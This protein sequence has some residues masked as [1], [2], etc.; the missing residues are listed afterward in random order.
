MRRFLFL[1]LLALVLAGLGACSKSSK[2]ESDTFVYPLTVGNEW[3]YRRVLHCTG[4]GCELGPD[5]IRCSILVRVVSIDTTTAP[6]PAYRL[7]AKTFFEDG[8][9]YGAQTLYQNRADGLYELA[10]EDT[11][12]A[13]F[14]GRPKAGEWISPIHAY[15]PPPFRT[16]DALPGGIRFDSTAWHHSSLLPLQYPLKGTWR[17]ITGNEEYKWDIDKTVRG[18]EKVTTKAG[19][20]DCFKI[21]W[22]YPLGIDVACTEYVSGYGLFK[23]IWAM[24]IMIGD[25]LREYADVTELQRVHLAR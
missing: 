4:A 1:G 16:T 13:T 3:V 7:D 6:T 18:R 10:A 23:R 24:K 22:Q 14:Y 17:Y 8:S 21:D 25:S 5:T 19:E 12:H 15:L 2:P 11:G 20:Y 9:T